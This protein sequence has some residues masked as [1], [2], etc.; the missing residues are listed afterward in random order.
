MTFTDDVVLP[1]WF[2]RLR[3]D[4]L[5]IIGEMADEVKACVQE[6]FLEAEIC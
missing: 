5:T 4:K 2:Y 6:H 1:E 3:I